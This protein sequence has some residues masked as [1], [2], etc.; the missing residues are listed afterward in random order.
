MFYL[1]LL[2]S[3][4]KNC[5]N[6]FDI[7]NTIILSLPSYI[8]NFQSC[9]SWLFFCLLVSC[10]LLLHFPPQSCIST[11]ST[12]FTSTFL[13]LCDPFF[14]LPVFIKGG[15]KAEGTEHILKSWM[16][17]PDLYPVCL[18]GSISCNKQTQTL[19][20]K[21]GVMGKNENEAGLNGYAVDS[22]IAAKC[23]PLNYWHELRLMR[24]K[25]TFHKGKHHREGRITSVKSCI[26]TT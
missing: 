4:M 24:K 22:S 5:L 16:S 18:R 9:L 11:F 25:E 10:S 23:C 15:V 2:I 19:P 1:L 20:D 6:L 26:K 3:A 14:L 8:A 13:P 17:C 12:Y 7:S 21:K